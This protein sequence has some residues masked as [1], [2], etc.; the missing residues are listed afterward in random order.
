MASSRLL[1]ETDVHV[2]ISDPAAATPCFRDAESD[3][4][5]CLCYGNNRSGTAL[6][7][8]GFVSLRGFGKYPPA[9]T[10]L[11]SCGFPRQRS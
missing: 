11:M 4:C 7:A 5:A 1:E 9:L 10:P 2:E 6:D 8:R 3:D